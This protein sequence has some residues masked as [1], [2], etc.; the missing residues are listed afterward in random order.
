MIITFEGG[1]GAG[2][3][4][5][6]ARLCSYLNIKGLPWLSIR[7][8]G[9]SCFSE[10]ARALFLKHEMDVM[11][12]LLLILASRRQNISEVIEPGLKGGRIV[13]MDRLSIPRSSTRALWAGSVVKPYRGSCG[14]PGPG[15]NP[16]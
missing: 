10:E 11:A 7:E 4:T 2:K 12:E 13:V 3:S 6:V 15:S 16:T 8:P 9:G 1:E 5:N 14:R